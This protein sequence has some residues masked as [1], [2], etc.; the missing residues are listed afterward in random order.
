MVIRRDV[1]F[2]KEGEWDWEMDDGKKYNF[3]PVLNEKKE[4]YKDH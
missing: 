1:E 4:S 3:L 2:D